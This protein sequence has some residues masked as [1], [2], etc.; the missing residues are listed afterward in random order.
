MLS[1]LTLQENSQLFSNRWNFKMHSCQAVVS[2]QNKFCWKKL[3]CKRIKINKRSILLF[4][5][6]STT[7]SVT[8]CASCSRRSPTFPSST[9]SSRPTTRAS[10]ASDSST[11][12]SQISTKFLRKISLSRSKKSSPRELLTWL[13]QVRWDDLHIFLITNLELS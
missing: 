7:S 3:S 4:F 2:C 11:R 12:A 6:S 5:R 1:T 10:S 8:A 13:R 9:S